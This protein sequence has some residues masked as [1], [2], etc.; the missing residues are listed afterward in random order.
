[1]PAHWHKVFQNLVLLARICNP[2]LPA[3]RQPGFKRGISDPE[4]T[5][6]SGDPLQHEFHDVHALHGIEVGHAPVGTQ[7]N[8]QHSAHDSAFFLEFLFDAVVQIG[9]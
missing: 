8:M 9:K 4:R 1:M 2:S 3:F 6:H 7:H 5:P